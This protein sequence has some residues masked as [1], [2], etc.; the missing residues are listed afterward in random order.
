MNELTLQKAIDEAKR[1]IDRAEAL[2]EVKKQRSYTYNGKTEYYNDPSTKQSASVRR[3]SMDLTRVL[4][5]LRLN[6]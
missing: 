3:A 6:R 2:K 1:F 5:D 4:A